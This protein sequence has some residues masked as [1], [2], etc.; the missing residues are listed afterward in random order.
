MWRMRFFLL[1]LIV[2]AL[3]ALQG[4][5]YLHSGEGA[6]QSH[7][8]GLAARLGVPYNTFIVLC[9][10]A[11]LG[12]AAG[13]IGTFAVLRRRA[14]IGDAVSHA[15]LPGL[16]LAFLITGQRSFPALLAGA[17]CS[18]LLGVQTISWLTRNTRLKNDAALGVV[19]SVFFGA[20]IV[21]SRTIQD[22]PRGSQAGLD[23]FLFGKPAG[24]VSQDL[25]GV[26]FVALDVVLLVLLFYKEFKVLSFDAQFAAVQGFAV[27]WIDSLMLGLMVVATVIGL[28]AVGV[29]LMAALL[30]L[31]AVAARFW[32][33]RLGVQLFLAGGL[34]MAACAFGAWMSSRQADLPA[35]PVIV[36]T[37]ACAFMF[38]MLLAPE[39]GVA[40]RVLRQWRMRRRVAEQH[41]LRSLFELSERALPERP[42]V[43]F[44]A[45]L[46]ER[47]WSLGQLRGL[48]RAAARRGDVEARGEGWA[49][50]EGGLKRASEQA[51][52][53]RL[54]EIYLVQYAHIAADHVDRDA[55]EIEHLITPELIAEL[56]RRLASE[57]GTGIA[58]VPDS[59]HPVVAAA[60][61]GA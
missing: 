59:V 28:P 46:H 40:A 53:H 34:G 31:P 12:L 13:L 50:S 19:L 17:I 43:R 29:V 27:G 54:W 56:E 11:L 36:L 26:F 51:R 39:R 41:L 3:L 33:E 18:G 61:G 58:A 52:R 2:A 15:A 22:D 47:S 60:G 6:F 35:G 32:T 1:I 7:V 45:L 20:G 16:C 4:Y 21:L 23:S 14:L 5:L 57:A 55:D 24:M 10:T 42:A 37:A 44:D 25:I 9:G 38:S 48:L 49:L 30:I 8:S